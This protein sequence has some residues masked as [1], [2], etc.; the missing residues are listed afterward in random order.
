[1]ITACSYCSCSVSLNSLCMHVI[2]Y[3]RSLW[4]S[5]KNLLQQVLQHSTWRQG[6]PRWAVAAPCQNFGPYMRRICKLD[7]KQHQAKLACHS[8]MQV[9]HEH[10]IHNHAFNMCMHEKSVRRVKKQGMP[11]GHRCEKGART[12]TT[13]IVGHHEESPLVAGRATLIHVWLVGCERSKTI[14]MAMDARCG[15]STSWTE[16]R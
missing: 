5:K 12:P 10:M 9:I 15:Q 6:Y 2:S 14:V 7:I 8:M 1:M 3:I 16:H 11:H 4:E 13:V